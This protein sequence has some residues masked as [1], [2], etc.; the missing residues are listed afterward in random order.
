MERKAT[1]MA[2]AMMMTPETKRESR[3]FPA[4][5]RARDEERYPALKEIKTHPALDIF[6]LMR[7]DEFARLVWSIKTL[8]GLIHPIL[9]DES[10]RIIDGRCRLL[11]CSIAGVDPMLA[12]PV[13]GGADG[14]A[15]YLF[16]ANAA[17]RH[18]THSQRIMIT[19]IVD[20]DEDIPDDGF[21]DQILSHNLVR[22]NLNRS[23][24][25]IH[26][27][28]MAALFPDYPAKLVSEE[29][30]FILRHEDIARRVGEGLHLAEAYNRAIERDNEHAAAEEQ[31][32]RLEQLRV[33]DRFAAALV[34][35]G[36]YTLEQ[37][38]ARAEQA[39][40]EP[41]LAEHVNAI[42]VLGRRMMADALEIGRRL[43]ECRRYVRHDWI[44]WLD[45]ELGLSDRQALNFIRIHELAASRSEN[46]SDLDLP[47]SGLYLLAR[48]STP[49][50]VR[51]DVIG[52][53][54]AGETISFAEIKR[55]VSGET[56]TA[57]PVKGLAKLAAQLAEERPHD[58]LVEQLQALVLAL[59]ESEV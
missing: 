25:T 32:R 6:P 55:E 24:L 8:G 59:S 44:G 36:T 39:A 10:G 28:R 57:A 53:A 41:L 2:T 33:A 52:R 21:I 9:Q 42:R 51:D 31:Q 54:A 17:R 18:L 50:A 30:V 22:R 26:D 4:R 38:I 16:A 37:G 48:P 40:A 45:R 14:V 7:E 29:A 15:A 43:G 12:D 27:A 47:V 20:I 34:D 35:D 56:P 46:F 23:A 49:D 11:A 3:G 13:I 5:A 19:A 58:P 1:T